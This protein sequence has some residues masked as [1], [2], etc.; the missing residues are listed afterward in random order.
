[1]KIMI[2]KDYLYSNIYNRADLFAIENDD[3]FICEYDK[4]SRSHILVDELVSKC[5]DSINIVALQFVEG[6]IFVVN[7]DDKYYLRDEEIMSKFLFKYINGNNVYVDV[8][9][10]SG[11]LAAGLIKN[12]VVNNVPNIHILYAEPALYKDEDFKKEGYHNVLSE[13]IDGIKP[14]PGFAYLVPDDD[15]T[16]F[17]ALLGYEGGRFSYI[18]ETLNIT[19][20]DIIPVIGVP[21]YKPE[22]TFTAIWGNKIPFLKT[23]SWE[24]IRYAAANSIVDVYMLLSDILSK[25]NGK[26][27]KIAPIGTKPHV[28]GAILFALKHPK[29]VEVVYDNPKREYSKTE[30]V[31]NII[32]C[33]ISKLLDEN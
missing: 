2:N 27:I 32:D 6:D 19:E 7:G 5:G 4:E 16:K 3:V 11:R 23:Q 24:H 33:N 31:G 10:M 26:K 1:M 22:Y 18:V 20:K 17:V 30:G 28:I 15:E 21:G 29:E 25:N 9:G 12:L 14:M 8:T 13:K